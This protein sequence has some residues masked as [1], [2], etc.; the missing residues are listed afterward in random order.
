MI[1]CIATKAVIP[2]AIKL[3]NISGAFIAIRTPLHIKIANRIN[4]IAQPINPTSSPNIEKIKS[5]CGSGIYKYFCLLSPKPAPNKPPE[6]MAYKLWITCHP[7]PVASFHGSK[8]VVIL[9]VACANLGI[10][11]IAIPINGAATAPGN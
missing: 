2:T 7:S 10:F 6:P 9:F 4:T 1:T 5:L 3:P 8:K 11:A